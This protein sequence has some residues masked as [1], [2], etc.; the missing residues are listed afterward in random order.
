MV[1]VWASGK[2]G[3]MYFLTVFGTE[4]IGSSVAL[5]SVILLLIYGGYFLVTYFCS[6]NIIRT[7]R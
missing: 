3:A 7:K 2:V 1:F 5:T 4:R 6:R